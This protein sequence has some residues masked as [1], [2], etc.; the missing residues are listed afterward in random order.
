M[1][2]GE[3]TMLITNKYTDSLGSKQSYSSKPRHNLSLNTGS[4]GG[5]LTPC[6]QFLRSVWFSYEVN[7]INIVIHCKKKKKFSRNMNL[8]LSPPRSIGRNWEASLLVSPGYATLKRAAPWNAK[9]TNAGSGGVVWECVTI[10]SQRLALVLIFLILNES[11][12]P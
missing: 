3:S 11:I 9:G 7:H 8:T 10:G 12:S 2:T 1:T 6:Q 4:A 5:Q